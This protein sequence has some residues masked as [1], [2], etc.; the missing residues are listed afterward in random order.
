MQR[1][2]SLALVVAGLVAAAAVTAVAAV[3]GC[4]A[5]QA[6]WGAGRW[7]AG[8]VLAVA[9]TATTAALVRACGA[10][11]GGRAVVLG[12][13]LLVTLQAAGQRPEGDVLV[14]GNVRGYA[15]LLGGFAVLVAVL[16]APGR[17]PRRARG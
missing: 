10:G 16:I 4:V 17:S 3:L 8:L 9:L 13:W 11:L 2:P 1:R 5:H 12:V 15:Y 14:P 6:V 7:P